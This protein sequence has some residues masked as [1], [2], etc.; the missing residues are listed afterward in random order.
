M[1]P[2]YSF[3]GS[4]LLFAM[5]GT[6]F[7]AGA[8]EPLRVDITQGTSVALPIAIPEIAS[9]TIAGVAEPDAGIAVAR[10]IRADLSST[11]LYRLV[12]GCKVEDVQQDG[13]SAC[14]KVGAQAVLLARTSRAADGSL[15]V[16]CALFD[17]F[18]QKPEFV[19]VISMPAAQWRRAAHKCADF[20]FSGQTGDPGH[21]DTRIVHVA[22]SGP[23]VGR[24]KRVAIM[25]Y[26]GANQA[27]VTRGNELVA[28]PRI[29]PD[30][31][32]IVYMTYVKRQPRLIIHKLAEGTTRTIDLP[33]GM[34]FSPRF[35]PDGRHLAFSL[36]QG[37]NSDIYVLALADGT[38]ARL[39]DAQGTDTS[40]SYS[41]DGS[42]IVFES[43][44]SG[45]QQIYVMASDGGQQTRIS[46]GEGRYASPVWSPRGDLIAFTRLSADSFRIGVMR[47]DGSRERMLTN[48]WQDEG[49][50]WAPSGRAL[51]YLRT[52]SG[53]A[54]PELWITDLS[55]TAQRRIP[56]P[57]GGADPSWS[58]LRP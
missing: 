51:A 32:S 37:G 2:L 22:E 46:F 34:V 26:D 7:A 36:G 25:D 48:G 42:K 20:V 3:L 47:T 31:A 14:R 57:A 9:G 11:G 13:L 44:R 17:A 53:D 40:P 55:G 43:S 5:L 24:S 50:S 30:G 4:V 1:K 38:L 27:F 10:L 39:T 19:Q 16:S 58:G 45:R 56:L 15:R 21:F 12:D 49:P 23:K 8:N 41:P 35:S 52:R 33:A 18:A 54:L 28:M 6:P 29:A